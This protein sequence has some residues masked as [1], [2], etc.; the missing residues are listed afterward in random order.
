[1][2]SRPTFSFRKMYLSVKDLSTG[3]LRELEGE[4]GDYKCEKEQKKN[5]FKCQIECFL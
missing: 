1:M 3:L 5:N 2:I 4:S